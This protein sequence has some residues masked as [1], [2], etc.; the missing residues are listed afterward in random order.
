MLF[1]MPRSKSQARVL[2]V[3]RGIVLGLIRPRRVSSNDAEVC[4]LCE[5]FGE[6]SL[7][8]LEAKE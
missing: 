1:E 3:V 2:S 6:V 4:I 8:S 7:A 5:G